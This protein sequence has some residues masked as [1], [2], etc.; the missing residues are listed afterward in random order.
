MALRPGPGAG[1]AGGAAGGAGG[2]AA[3]AAR[4][5][6]AEH[7]GDAGPGSG[8]GRLRPAGCGAAHEGGRVERRRRRRRKTG[9]VEVGGV[10]R[11]LGVTGERW[12][13]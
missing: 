9:G 5:V 11:R 2:G 3:G 8:A 10:G 4:W 7:G 6:V 1:G 12:R 13:D